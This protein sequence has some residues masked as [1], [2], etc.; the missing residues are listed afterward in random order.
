MSGRNLLNSLNP[1]I[2]LYAKSLFFTWLW[3]ELSTFI[4]QRWS[5]PPALDRLHKQGTLDCLC[6]YLI[7]FYFLKGSEIEPYL[8]LIFPVF[9]AADYFIFREPI[10][11][12]FF[13]WLE[14]VVLAA[15]VFAGLK[16]TFLSNPGGGFFFLGKSSIYVSFFWLIFILFLFCR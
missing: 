9:L 16:I 7:L 12:Q 6:L 13:F 15:L 3:L 11:L 2:A 1:S 10:R 14:V 4:S 8:H 5:L